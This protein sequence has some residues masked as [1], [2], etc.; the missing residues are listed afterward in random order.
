MNFIDTLLVYFGFGYIR[1]QAILRKNISRLETNLK[2]FAIVSISEET[3]KLAQDLAQCDKATQTLDDLKR[4]ILLIKTHNDTITHLKQRLDEAL[5]K[6]SAKY[7]L[8]NI[9]KY[10]FESVHTLN[11]TALQVSE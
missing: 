2:A 10:S 11:E 3:Y 6:H 8:S 1:K 9:D 4:I 5:T 7:I